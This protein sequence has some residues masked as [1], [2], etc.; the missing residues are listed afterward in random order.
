MHQ[1]AILAVFLGFVILEI[2]L[3]RF[4]NKE[5][6]RLK[7]VA[8]EIVSPLNVFFVTVPFT[9]YAAGTL[10]QSY[11]PDYANAL[12]Q[13][14]FWQMFLLL[15]VFD[16]MAQYWWHRASH[17]FPILYNLHRAHHDAG[18]LN[19]RI[20]YRNGFFYYLPMP[21]LWFSGVL[22]YMGLGEVYIYYTFVKMSFIFGAHSSVRWDEPLY[23]I[24]WLSPVMWV[25]ERVFSTPST[26]SAH[27]GKN[28]SDG[29][30]HYKGNYG[31]M[32]FLWDVI[33]GTAKITRGYPDDYGLENLEEIS[34]PQLF[35]W[36]LVGATKGTVEKKPEESAEAA[37]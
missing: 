26:H 30:T 32:L 12:S 21:S 14:N 25:V 22:I 33:F 23:K 15:V 34:G 20:T 17:K 28:M 18:Y 29:V 13:L 27:H 1:I 11:F 36:P 9:I 4:M 7:D 6:T 37:E 24:K 19:S 5:R 8:V 2:L 31:N 16:D 35:M 10:A 3:G